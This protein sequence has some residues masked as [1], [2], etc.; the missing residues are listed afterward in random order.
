MIGVKVGVISDTHLPKKLESIP[1]GIFEAFRGVDLIVH[2]G[3]IL[4]PWVLDE[5]SLLAPVEAVAGNHDTKRFGPALLRQ[6]VLEL[7]DYKVGLIHGDTLG[8][9]HVTRSNLIDSVYRVIIDP[10]LEDE[11]DCI[12]FGHSHRPLIEI[13][14]VTFRSGAIREVLLFNPGSPTRLRHRPS[15]GILTLERRGIIAQLLLPGEL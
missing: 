10:F 4:E 14:P 1:Q 12:L 7:A 9:I 13:Y 11:V 8:E 2:L 5:L 3:D 6:K 15:L